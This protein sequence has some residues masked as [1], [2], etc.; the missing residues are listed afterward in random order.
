MTGG[1]AALPLH[2]K[3]YKGGINMNNISQEKRIYNWVARYE[4]IIGN[5][6]EAGGIMIAGSSSEV[7]KQLEHDCGNKKFECKIVRSKIDVILCVDND[8]SDGIICD[9]LWL[10][11][12]S[13]DEIKNGIC[14]YVHGDEIDVVFISDHP[15]KENV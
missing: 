15:I 6:M 3:T 12:L 10:R 2:H 5:I 8:I 13:D 9:Y 14:G 1:E 7:L 4:D 11:K